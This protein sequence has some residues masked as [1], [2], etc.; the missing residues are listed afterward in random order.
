VNEGLKEIIDVL[1]AQ[2][3]AQRQKFMRMIMDAAHK[4]M[5]KKK[6]DLML[7]VI[8]LRIMRYQRERMAAAR[9]GA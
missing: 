9:K 6:V 8:Y 4:P 2:P 3:F 1:K 5:P 7:T